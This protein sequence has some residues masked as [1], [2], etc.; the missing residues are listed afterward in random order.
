MTKKHL[1]RGFT[2]I[3]TIAYMSLL[4]IVGA[5]VTQNI[6]S[7]FSS[8]S[9]IRVGQDIETTAIQVLDKV[10]RDVRNAVSIVENQSSFNI[11]ESYLTLTVPNGTGGTDTVKYYAAGGRVNVDRNGVFMGSLSL[12]SITVNTFELRYING[13]STK[14]I[15]LWLGVESPI[16]DNP[17]VVYENFYTTVQIRD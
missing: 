16:R 3:E 6:V 14:A 5:V 10:S 11:P 9:Q 8:Y 4:V 12:P 13:T 7:L 15:K 1:T 17:G 2:L